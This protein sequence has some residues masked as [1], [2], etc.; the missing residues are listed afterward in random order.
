MLWMA[1]LVQSLVSYDPVP[2]PIITG[3]EHRSTCHHD[4]AV[5][6]SQPQQQQQQQQQMC[7]TVSLVLF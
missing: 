4:T 3:P 6:S 7:T 1:L 2:G 5:H